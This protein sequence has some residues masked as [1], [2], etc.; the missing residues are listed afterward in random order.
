[1]GTN[2]F[3]FLVE[4]RDNQDK[5]GGNTAL[6]HACQKVSGDT[7]LTQTLVHTEK[8][9]QYKKRSKRGCCCMAH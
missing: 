8:E 5:N 3:V 6:T 9:A 1:M 2:L 4:H 7:R